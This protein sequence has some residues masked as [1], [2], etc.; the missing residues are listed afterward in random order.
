MKRST[1]TPR[2]ALAAA[3]ATTAA[4]FTARDALATPP[5]TY[6]FG[7]RAS[8]LAGAVSA[9]GGDSSSVYYNPAALVRAT[10]VRV[11]VGYFYAHHALSVNGFDSA[12]DPAHGV[13]GGVVAPGRLFAIPFAF[14]LA[15]HLPDDRLSRSRALPQL[16]PRWELFDN[17]VQLLYLAADVAIAP[18]RWLRLGG[19]I[20]FISSTRGRL[21]IYGDIAFPQASASRLRHAVDAD[22]RAVRY[23]QAGVQVDI[24]D[25]LT[26]SAVYRGEFRLALE[27]DATVMGSVVVGSG[28]GG[29][30]IPGRYDLVSRSTAVFLPHNFVVGAKFTPLPTLTLLA[31]VTYQNFA[32]YPNPTARLDVALDLT[33][34]PGLN[35]PI[36]ALPPGVNPAPAAFRDTVSLR[37]GAEWRS[38]IRAHELAL[39]GGYRFEPSPVPEQSSSESNFLD[40]DR[41]AVSL[42]AGFRIGGIDAVR[43]GVSFDLY[44]TLQALA[45]R[46]YRK[47]NPADTVGDQSLGGFV[48]DLG[49]TTSIAF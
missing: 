15:T 44:S 25:K 8:A 48:F 29:T 34:P 9:D 31:D 17:R 22:L 24:N 26:L 13:V 46:M 20:S 41:H 11:D 6:G 32:A 14:G 16:Q 38:V 35:V 4:L 30:R 27:F 3:F 47:S 45:P 42:G 10:G 21:D 18:V 33:P 36:P 23:A 7:A 37:L 39:R 5:G 40:C 12:V 28:A 1:H 43:G 19:G 49:I 2:A